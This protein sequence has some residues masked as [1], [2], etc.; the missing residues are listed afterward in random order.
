[1]TTTTGTSQDAKIIAALGQALEDARPAAL[2]TVVAS[3][4]SVPGKPGAQMV[5]LAD[6]ETIGTVGGGSLEHKITLEARQC[7]DQGKSKE[8]SYDL[9]VDTELAMSCGGS[10]RAF[11]KVFQAASQLIIVGSGHIGHELYKIGR[12]QGFQV[13]VID[14]R[15]ELTSEGRFPEA[16]RLITED[17]PAT[18][19]EYKLHSDCYVTIATASHDT[20][21]LALEAVIHADAAYIGMIGSS[22]K[23]RQIFSYLQ[24]QGIAREKIEQIFAPMGLNIASIRPEEIALAIIGEILLVKNSGSPEHMRTIKKNLLP[25]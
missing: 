10:L 9:Q 7:I 24:S 20:D 17:L 11:I 2:V 4:G 8:V 12:L 25:R 14:N 1:M 5:V 23:I 19:R 3:A 18:L 13:V 6:G 22:K 21:R 16:R 15:P